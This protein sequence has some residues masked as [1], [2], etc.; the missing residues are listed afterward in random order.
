[1]IIKK[2]LDCQEFISGDGAFL[3]ELLHAGKSNFKFRYS[4]AHA[5]LKPAKKT[6][7]HKLKSTEVYYIIKGKGLMHV[8]RQSR[9]VNEGDA[10]YIPADK[11]QY[12]ENIGRSDLVFLCIVDPAWRREDEE[13]LNCKKLMRDFILKKPRI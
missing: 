10:V 11:Q 2:L 8:A 5:I 12:I 13:I 4:L 7:P 9:E 1:M 3:R 6:R